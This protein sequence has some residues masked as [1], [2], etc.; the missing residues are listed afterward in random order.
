MKS[1]HQ[2]VIDTMVKKLT[3]YGATPKTINAFKRQATQIVTKDYQVLSKLTNLNKSISS[4]KPTLEESIN[5]TNTDKFKHLQ[6]YSENQKSLAKVMTALGRL[7]NNTVAENLPIR[8][9]NSNK[10][11][12]FKVN[13]NQIKNCDA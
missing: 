9:P 11:I 5:K 1:S 3:K 8:F 13:K 6:G 4:E 7:K 2:K 10:F 12:E